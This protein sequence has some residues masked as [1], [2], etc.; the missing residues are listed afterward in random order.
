MSLKLRE[1]RR[2]EEEELLLVFFLSRVAGAGNIPVIMA[3]GIC[4]IH[5]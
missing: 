2:G 5:L 1:E 4:I 3:D